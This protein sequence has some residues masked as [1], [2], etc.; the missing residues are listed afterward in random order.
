MSITMLG[1]SKAKTNKM[2][3]NPKLLSNQVC[4]KWPDVHCPTVSAGTEV[5]DELW[6]PGAF[7]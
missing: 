1:A 4:K 5:Y 2:W 7:T 3:N 6:D